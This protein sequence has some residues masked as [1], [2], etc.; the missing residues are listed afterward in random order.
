LWRRGI[1]FGRVQASIHAVPVPP[2]LKEGAPLYWLGRAGPKEATLVERLLALGPSTDTFVHLDYH[3]INVLADSRGI[4]AVIDWTN[5]SAGD[6]RA[7]LAWTATLLQIGPI[8]P[9]PLRPLLS[10]ARRLLY[11]A[12]RRGYE[13]A[14]GPMPDVTPFMAWAGT[15]YLN[16]VEPRMGRPE[17]WGSERDLDAMRRWTERWKARAGLE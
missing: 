13:R 3:P 17:V 15:V 7:D 5:A 9:G 8:P 11:L 16:E 2:V 14:A 6:R 12:W 10:A 4:T 1:T